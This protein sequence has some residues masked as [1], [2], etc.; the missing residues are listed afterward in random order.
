MQIADQY[1][2]IPREAISRFLTFCSECQ[3]KPPSQPQQP[4]K[5]SGAD[6][7]LTEQQLDSAGD[8]GGPGSLGP[9]VTPPAT[10]PSG[11]GALYG[12]YRERADLVVVEQ[13]AVE[14]LPVT[15]ENLERL[16]QT[17]DINLSLPI[18]STYL[19]RM[20]QRTE[21]CEETGGDQTGDHDE[22]RC[23]HYCYTSDKSD[24]TSHLPP[25]SHLSLCLSCLINNYE[26]Y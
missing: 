11:G 18:T 13:E 16:D 8:P 15:A 17:T 12:L 23:R 21:P 1:A 24:I 4:A 20:R 26:K 7:G 9:L 19:R 3:R 14:I 22:V 6:G 25:T 5:S 2:F 10:P